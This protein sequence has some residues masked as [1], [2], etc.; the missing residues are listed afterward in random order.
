MK[1]MRTINATYRAIQDRATITQGSGRQLEG[2]KKAYYE[3]LVQISGP[4][5]HK[6][7][8]ILKSLIK[9]YKHQKQ[10]LIELEELNAPFRE[11]S[12]LVSDA[13]ALLKGVINV[14]KKG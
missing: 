6:P 14:F 5:V 4:S 9:A 13:K 8:K 2:T 7:N 10:K 11:P 3:R 1:V 12:P